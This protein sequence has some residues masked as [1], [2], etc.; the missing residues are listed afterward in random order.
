MTSWTE[1]VK[2]VAQKKGISYRQAL[3][4]ASKTYK[5]GKGTVAQK[6]RAYFEDHKPIPI[7]AMKRG[8]MAYDMP[9]RY[10]TPPYN[11][12][13]EPEQLE[14]EEEEKISK[15]FEMVG[16]GPKIVK[17]PE[18]KGAGS[19]FM[20]KRHPSMLSPPPYL[21]SFNQMS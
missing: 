5:K 2:S 4:V 9:D 12:A 17:T 21:K 1:H 16:Q 14:E 15:P 13:P 10:N 18:E 8:R 7:I 11:N 6:T 3:K 20:F 19:K